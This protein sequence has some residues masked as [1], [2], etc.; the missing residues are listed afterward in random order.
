MILLVLMLAICESRACLA[1]AEDAPQPVPAAKLSAEEQPAQHKGKKIKKD[2]DHAAENKEAREQRVVT[3]VQR[4]NPE[5]AKLLAH[6]K[7]HKPQQYD[8]AVR[9]LARTVTILTN[10]KAKDDRL[11]EL[12]L[13]AWQAK[14]RVQLLA[15]QSMTGEKEGL[16]AKLREAIQEELKVKADEL[17]FRREKSAAWYNRQIDNIQEDREKLVEARLKKILTASAKDGQSK[18]KKPRKRSEPGDTAPLKSSK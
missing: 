1:Q 5:L 3:F 18:A 4:Q 15:A 12:Q 10:A 7:Q 14:T 11:Y 13:R 16:E 6:L 9:E 17:A 8:E 2:K